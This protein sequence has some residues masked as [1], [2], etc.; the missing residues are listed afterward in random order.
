MKKICLFVVCS[1]LLLSSCDTYTGAGAYAGGS[2]GAILGSAIGGLSGGPRGS[3]MGTLI[4]MAGGAAVGAVVGSAADK[5]ESGRRSDYRSQRSYSS[6][7]SNDSQVYISR[8]N[9]SYTYS[10]PS[11]QGSDYQGNVTNNSEIFDSNNGG[12]DRL[13][14]FN[15]TDYTGNYTAQQPTTS[16]PS[17]TVDQLGANYS[18]SPTLEIVN[19]RFVDAHEDKVLSRNETCKLIFEIRN[20]G[21]QTV[22]NVVPT[23]IETTGNKHIFISPSVHIEKIVPGDGVRYTAMVKA[24]DRLR[25]GYARFCVSVIHDGKA[26]SKVNEF[27]IQTRK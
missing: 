25:N 5:A 17:A 18:Y 22:Y 24:D 14:D 21:K 20:N 26:I 2:I 6:Q 1:S 4:G 9:G 16:M 3:D 12:D 13:Y 27:N 19:A 23:V 8:G 7:R 15:G 10:N 11:Q